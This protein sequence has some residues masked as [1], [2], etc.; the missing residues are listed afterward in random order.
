MILVPLFDLKFLHELAA[1]A[2]GTSNRRHQPPMLRTRERTRGALRSRSVEKRCC[3]A[4]CAQCSHHAA[5]ERRAETSSI[6]QQ[7]ESRRAEP[8][9]HVKKGGVSAHCESSALRGRAANGFNT[10]SRINE[11]VADSD[12]RGSDQCKCKPGRQPNQRQTHCFDHC[13]DER[14]PCAAKPVRHMAK[15]DA[16][17]ATPGTQTTAMTFRI[18]VCTRVVD[19]TRLSGATNSKVPSGSSVVASAMATKPYVP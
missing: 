13:A 1:T 2:V 7:A 6:R 4:G 14:D 5:N 8:E 3:N 11:R 17:Q 15:Q 16:R 9:R 10:E 12:Q 18:P 19:G